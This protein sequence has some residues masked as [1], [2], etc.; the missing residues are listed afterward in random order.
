M[1]RRRAYYLEKRGAK[2]YARLYNPLTGKILPARSTGE[3]DLSKAH[4]VAASW[5]ATGTIGLPKVGTGESTSLADA[6]TFDTLAQ[7]V[8]SLDMTPAQARRLVATL[9]ARGLLAE[10]NTIANRRLTDFLHEFF[11]YEKSLFVRE[12][13]AL[14]QRIGKTHCLDMQGRVRRSWTPYF[15]DKRLADVTRADLKA[16][17]QHLAA[18]GLAANSIN[19]TMMVGKTALAWCER[20]GVLL[21]DPAKGLPQYKGAVAS[22]DILTEEEWSRLLAVEWADERA[23][24]GTLVAGTAGLRLGEILALTVEDIGDDRLAVRGSW[25]NVER[26][27]KSTKTG[28]ARTAVL[29]PRVRAALLALAKK[30][31]NKTG[32]RWVFWSKVREDGPCDQKTLTDGFYLALEAIG[33]TEAERVARNLV[34]HGTRHLHAARLADKVDLRTVALSTGHAPDG[35]MAAHYASHAQEAHFQ[36][37][38]AA[39]DQAFG[40]EQDKAQAVATEGRANVQG[41]DHE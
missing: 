21:V 1:A 23:A 32:P 27:V 26:V 33:I 39:V 14:G 29:L 36:A 31:P 18:Q 11:D 24:V 25:S 16:F 28:T 22:R 15:G 40:T 9:E 10:T 17:G 12:K 7:A 3:T 19:K 38:R 4:A 20:E 13:I 37:L 41:A 34:F 6:M 30:N 2:F 5:H 8:K 35:A